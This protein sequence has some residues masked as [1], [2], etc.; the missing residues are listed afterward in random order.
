M[1]R[2][3]YLH[4]RYKIVSL[5]KRSFMHALSNAILPSQ[6]NEDYL[7]TLSLFVIEPNVR[8][9]PLLLFML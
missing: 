7:Y 4:S 2:M 8:N 3:N 6:P 5:I 1:A 9:E